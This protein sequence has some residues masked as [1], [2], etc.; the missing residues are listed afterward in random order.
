MWRTSVRSTQ[1]AVRSMQYAVALLF[2][3]YLSLCLFL[4]YKKLILYFANTRP[5]PFFFNIKAHLR[6]RTEGCLRSLSFPMVE[7]FLLCVASFISPSPAPLW[8]FSLA[9]WFLICTPAG[10]RI[11]LKKIFYKVLISPPWGDGAAVCVAF[12]RIVR[13]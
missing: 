10:L 2:L 9:G 5:R 7:K 1:Y 8:L 3:L 13:T 6:L 12:A 4:P 11:S